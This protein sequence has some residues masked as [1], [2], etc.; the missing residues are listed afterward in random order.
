MGNAGDEPALQRLGPPAPGHEP[1][2]RFT[3]EPG[4]GDEVFP[5]PGPEPAEDIGPA[6]G[7][8]D[9]R[10]QPALA[11]AEAGDLAHA[12]PGPAR[13]PPGRLRQQAPRPR[14]RVGALVAAARR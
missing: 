11:V 1:V 6:A 7:A 4:A 9:R 12:D 14:Q 8:E 2:V 13:G 5:A 3:E 10:R